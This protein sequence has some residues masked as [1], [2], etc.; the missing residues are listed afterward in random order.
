MFVSVASSAST[1]TATFSARPFTWFPSSRAAWSDTLRG[2]RAKN[3]KPTM[4]APASSAASSVSGVER[5]QILTKTDMAGGVL[6]R[7]RDRSKSGDRAPHQHRRGQVLD[8]R[9]DRLEQ[10]D[11]ARPGAASGLAAAELEQV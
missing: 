9:A 5:P 2:L 10:R 11:F 1:V 6:A 3:M 7:F 4:S 8:R